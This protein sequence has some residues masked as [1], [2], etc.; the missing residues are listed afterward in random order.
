[1]FRFKE[2]ANP[3]G[4]VHRMAEIEEKLSK[5][6]GIWNEYKSKSFWG[7]KS[8]RSRLTHLMLVAL[9]DFVMTVAVVSIPGPDKKATVLD[10]V[11]RLYEYTA[12]EALPIWARPLAEPV[13]HYIVYVLASYAIDWIVEKYKAGKWREPVQ[14]GALQRILEKTGRSEFPCVKCSRRDS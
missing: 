9:D 2:N 6:C 8:S 12:R 10:A 14:T 5:Y 3:V 11:D 7:S 4:V 13:K 1:M